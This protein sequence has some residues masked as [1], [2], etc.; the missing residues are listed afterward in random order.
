MSSL[1]GFDWM[2]DVYETDNWL[3]EEQMPAKSLLEELEIEPLHIFQC[4]MYM[5]QA[6]FFKTLI[7]PFITEEH[8]H[9]FWGP[10]LIVSLYALILSIGR[11][12]NVSWVYVI[13][14][15][16]S[17]ILHL[18]CRSWYAAST[19]AMHVGISG[20]SVAPFLPISLMVVLFRPPIV[21]AQILTYL[22]I[23]WSSFSAMK[24]YLHIFAGEPAE[25]KARRIL[26]AM[27]V[28]LMELYFSSLLPMIGWN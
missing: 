22:G 17:F 3:E 8:H 13:W 19:L 14:M 2:F 6:P 15:V 9:D 12:S 25:D 18:T 11:V 10:C 7:N 1:S 23:A 4:T 27:P 20:Y 16:S 5:F 28:L 24:T 26:L 21:V